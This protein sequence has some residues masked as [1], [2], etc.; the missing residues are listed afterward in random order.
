M[1]PQ[2]IS[3]SRWDNIANIHDRDQI[4]DSFVGN[5]QFLSIFGSIDHN[6]MIVT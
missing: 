3:M 1:A 2:A 4:L 6:S 5:N